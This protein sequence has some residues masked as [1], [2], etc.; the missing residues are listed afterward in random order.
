LVIFRDSL[1]APQIGKDFFLASL[2]FSL[3]QGPICR[4]LRLST[5]FSMPSEDTASMV[6]IVFMRVLSLFASS[7]CRCGQSQPPNSFQNG[8]EQLSRHRHFRHRLVNRACAR[9]LRCFHIPPI[10]S[11][12][13]ASFQLHGSG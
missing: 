10:N 9:R 2:G 3:A 1:P 5:R 4:Q 8:P 13:V 12:S 11:R 7:G 6:S